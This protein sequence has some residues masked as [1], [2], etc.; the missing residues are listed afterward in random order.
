MKVKLIAG[1][2][3]AAIFVY[4]GLGYAGATSMGSEQ[5][6]PSNLHFLL[7]EEIIPLDEAARGP[8]DHERLLYRGT[9]LDPKT[10]KAR[11]TE[12]GFCIVADVRRQSR[13]VCQ[14]VFA[15][16]ATSSLAAADQITAQ[17]IFDDV[18]TAKP[19][20]TGITGGTGRYA[21]ARGEI[22]ARPASGGLV[23]VVFRFRG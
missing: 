15:P 18:Q 20:R 23:D 10:R 13:L 17:T 8:S 6:T 9:L 11:G 21:G 4:A 16:S 22:V 12:L 7:R 3:V 1:A 14:I 2:A 19:Q 5:A